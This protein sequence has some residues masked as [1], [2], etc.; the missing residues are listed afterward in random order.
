M[1]EPWMSCGHG[2]ADDRL[3]PSHLAQL[4]RLDAA[5]RAERRREEAELAERVERRR[6]WMLTRSMEFA[7]ATGEPWDERDPF[8]FWPSVEA[9]AE[10]LYAAQDREAR[11]ADRIAARD[12]GLEHLLP[13]TLRLSADQVA[14]PAAESSSSSAPPP[15]ARSRT[16]DKVRE[17][18][19][20]GGAVKCACP[21]CVSVRA[22]RSAE[23]SR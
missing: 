9:Q 2:W 23:A 3:L 1:S 16:L 6:E 22:Q 17:L 7:H 19:H 20:R 11:R 14:A 13:A 15:A 10:A 12:A 4:R 18:L 21:S 8:K 5:E